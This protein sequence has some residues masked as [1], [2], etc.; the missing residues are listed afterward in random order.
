LPGIENGDLTGRM[1]PSLRRLELWLQAAVRVGG[2]DDWSFIKLHTHGAQEAN[3]AML[4]GEP[5]AAFHQALSKHAA[6]RDFQYYYVTAF[7]MARLVKQ[8]EEGL[9]DP[10]FSF[11]KSC[12]CAS[13]GSDVIDH[14]VAEQRQASR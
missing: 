5:M 11:G 6:V 2:R 9:A 8:A 1:P 14:T 4:L 10:D 12:S 13:G 7:E 3:A